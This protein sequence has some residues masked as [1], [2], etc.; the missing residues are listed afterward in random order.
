MAAVGYVSAE[1]FNRAK[2]A[3]IL[4]KVADAPSL[5]PSSE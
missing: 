5:L 1:E 4:K 3:P 2:Q